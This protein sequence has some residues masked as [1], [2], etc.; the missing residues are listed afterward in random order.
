MAKW[1]DWG[2]GVLIM[3]SKADLFCVDCC[4]LL[5]I[6]CFVLSEMNMIWMERTIDISIRLM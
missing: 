5:T 4:W 2:A 6:L 1:R 3:G